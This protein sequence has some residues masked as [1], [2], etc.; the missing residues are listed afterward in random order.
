[1][2]S[3]YPPPVFVHMSS[4]GKGGLGGF[5]QLDIWGSDNRTDRTD[6]WL[7]GLDGWERKD[8]LRWWGIL[9]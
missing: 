9:G 2:F 6:W 5:M 7:A 1:M 8:K 3:Y 4:K